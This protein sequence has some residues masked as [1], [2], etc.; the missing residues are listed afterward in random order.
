ML[1]RMLPEGARLKVVG[2]N[3]FIQMYFGLPD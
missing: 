3:G 1:P 2:L